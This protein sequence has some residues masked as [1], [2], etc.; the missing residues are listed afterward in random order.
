MRGYDTNRP[1]IVRDLMAERVTAVTV[2]CACGARREVPIERL[3]TDLTMQ[4]LAD[5][6]RCLKCDER[7]KARVEPAWHTR[8]PATSGL[9]RERDPGIDGGA[10]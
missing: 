8:A 9:T 5:R 10:E 2:S 6:F 4:G 7:G 3:P 1:L